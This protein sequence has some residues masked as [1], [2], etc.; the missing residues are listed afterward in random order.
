MLPIGP[1]M[2]EHRLIE[3][4]I[5]I[6]RSEIRNIEE[7]H[8]ADPEVIDVVVDFVRTYADQTHHGKE[9]EILFRELAKKNLNEQ[10]R[11][12][13][14]ELMEEHAYGRSL[15]RDLV[16]AKERY[17][18]SKNGALKRIWEKLNALVEFYPAHIKKEDRN[19]FL[20]AM[21]YL[22]CEEQEAML[23]EMWAFDRRMIHQ[24]YKALV[25]QWQS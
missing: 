6:M 19:F 5:S 12:V 7:Y 23:Q 20:A 21:K 10:D 24:K 4:M 8:R 11:H 16:E 3:K 15:V 25:E 13:M 14:R 9:E 2:I 18:E 22:S 1:L 17:L